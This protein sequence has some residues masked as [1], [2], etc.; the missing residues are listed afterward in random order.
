[1][2]FKDAVELGRTSRDI[3]KVA[4][5][6]V[7]VAER[8]SAHL[9]QTLRGPEGSPACALVRVFETQPFD[10]LP[11][12]R[13]QF[14]AKLLGPTKPF[15]GLRCLTLLG[16]SGDEPDWNFPERSRGHYAIPLPDLGMIERAPMIARLLSELGI[17]A[18]HVVRSSSAPNPFVLDEGRRSF[19]VFHV[20]DAPGSAFIPA[21]KTFVDTCGIRSVVG[22]GGLLPDGELFAVILFSRVR[23]PRETAV[24]FRMLALSV[25][26]AFLP[27]ASS[28]VFPGSPA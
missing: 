22:M 13:Q 19:N 26:L 17:A 28:Q 25:K 15:P 2:R 16:S 10:R 7:A 9:Y 3:C 14:A 11:L 21:Q 23:I 4:A 8:L 1:M 6:H 18:E 20:E 12:D 24:L 5:T 27:F